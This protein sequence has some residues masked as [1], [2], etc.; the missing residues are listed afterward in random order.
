MRK[1]VTCV[2]SQSQIVRK[3]TACV[4]SRQIIDDS[5]ATHFAGVAALL[6]HCGLGAVVFVSN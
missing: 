5:E 6:L 4:M 1:Q 2:T 3:L